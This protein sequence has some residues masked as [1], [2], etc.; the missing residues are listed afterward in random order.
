M[1]RSGPVNAAERGTFPVST[2]L[3]S[4][5][6]FVSFRNRAILTKLSQRRWRLLRSRGNDVHG[7][8][9]K[10]RERYFSLHKIH[11]PNFLI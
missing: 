5:V 3:Q 8:Q 6:Y 1:V 2:R 11:L 9:R 4:F 10:R 7:N